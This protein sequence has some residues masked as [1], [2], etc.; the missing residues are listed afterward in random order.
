MSSAKFHQITGYSAVVGAVLAAVRRDAGLDQQAMA[1]KVGITQSAW[2]RI[3]TG[4]TQITVGQ[5]ATAARVLRETPSGILK[6]ADALANELSRG[7]VRVEDRMPQEANASAIIVS[8]AALTGF[9]SDLL[10]RR[11]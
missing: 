11:E 8:A 3:E 10:T 1:E 4:T 7:G 9:A 2:S 6:T 5:L